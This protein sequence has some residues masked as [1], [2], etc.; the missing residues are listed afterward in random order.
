M[1][2]N[3]IDLTA[4]FNIYFIG[5]KNEKQRTKE[6]NC[7]SHRNGFEKNCQVKYYQ[8]GKIK[9]IPLTYPTDP[10]LRKPITLESLNFKEPNFLGNQKKSQLAQYKIFLFIHMLYTRRLE[11]LITEC[12]RL[13]LQDLEEEIISVLRKNN[14]HFSFLKKFRQKANVNQIK[15]LLK[16]IH[17]T[18]LLYDQNMFGDFMLKILQLHGE[19]I[20]ENWQE[21]GGSEMIPL[22]IPEFRDSFLEFQLTP[23]GNLESVSFKITN[24]FLFLANSE[25][26][27]SGGVP[28]SKYDSLFDTNKMKGMFD[29]VQYELDSSMTVKITESSSPCE[30]EFNLTSLLPQGFKIPKNLFQCRSQTFKLPRD[31]KGGKK[32]RSKKKRRKFTRKRKSVS[33]ESSSMA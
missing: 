26:I 30:I 27:K 7:D 13:S 5:T 15:S 14:I 19:L 17:L 24:K 25:E 1:F 8:D 21:K 16:K 28:I 32:K 29:I 4:I 9:S 10:N 6:I 22:R 12:N 20:N 33:S 23:S 31:E 2:R 3:K 18:T 11:S